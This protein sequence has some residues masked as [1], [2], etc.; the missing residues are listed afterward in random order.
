MAITVPKPL[1]NVSNGLLR[2]V[3]DNRDGTR[4]FTWFVAEPINNYDIAVNAGRLRQV[5]RPPRA[6]RQPHPHLLALR[7]HK[8]ARQQFK[9]VKTMLA[10]FEAGLAPTPGARTATSWSR[11]RTSA[12]STRAP[13]RTA[14]LQNG[15]R[16]RDLSGTGRGLDWDFIIIHESAHE[17]WGNS[18]TSADLADMWVHEGFANYAENLY[19]ECLHGKRV[20]PST[21]SAPGSAS[22]TTSR[23]SPT[24]EE[25]EG[26]G[27]HVPQGGN[28]L[29]LIRQLV[30]DDAK[31]RSVPAACRDVPPRH[32]HRRPGA[33]VHHHPDRPRP[34]RHL[35]PVPHHH[36]VP[37]P[38]GEAARRPA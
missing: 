29:H 1:Q 5:H 10:C 12:W 17:W 2:S 19:V 18:L 34:R 20:T 30:N 38:G 31:W 11:R 14:T 4:T 26:L 7:A 28:M 23:S 15:Y 8:K 16:G 36:L 37:T 24:S 33:P 27:R 32:R 6:R 9:Q 3:K 21:P 25:P 35:P 22:P 13:W